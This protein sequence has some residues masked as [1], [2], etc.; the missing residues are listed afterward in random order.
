MWRIKRYLS[1]MPS[2][3]LARSGGMSLKI[4]GSI[5]ATS[6][7]T[8]PSESIL[9]AD[10]TK[11]SMLSDGRRARNAGACRYSLE[12]DAPA[13]VGRRASDD[14]LVALV[15]ENDN[16]QVRR[17]LFAYGAEGAEVEKHAAVGIERHY[18]PVRQ[19]QRHP[20][21]K[22]VAQPSKSAN[23]VP[24]PGMSEYHSGFTPPIDVTTRSSS[25]T[26]PGQLFQ[27]FVA[28]H[29]PSLTSGAR[30]TTAVW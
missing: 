27:E 12:I 19:V 24:L 22:G 26:K 9:V 8:W 3:S 10:S 14:P 20:Q 16:R 6:S 1:S 15:V 30:K 4:P 5:F 17:Q 25:V 29:L 2:L 23:I 21:C 11:L 13:R 7:P 28:F 18:A